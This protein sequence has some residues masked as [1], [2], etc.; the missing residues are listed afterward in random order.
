M[1]TLKMDP[2]GWHPPVLKTV[3]TTREGITELVASID[4]HRRFLVDGEFLQERRRRHFKSQV[5]DIVLNRL[6][7]ELYER[8]GGESGLDSMIGDVTGG[9]RSPHQV[10][11]EVID[12]MDEVTS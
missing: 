4:E 2:S 5:R 1:L 3:A 11:S 6:E 10:A 8:H 12:G 9:H 7:R